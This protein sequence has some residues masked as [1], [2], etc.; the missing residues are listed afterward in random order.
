MPNLRIFIS[1][2]FDKDKDLKSNFVR[3]ARDYTPHRVEDCSLREA[4][5]DS[6]WKDKASKSIR[7]CDLVIVLVGQDTHNAP[8]VRTEI[9]I[10]RGL[11]K[12][13]FQVVPQGRPY[14]GLSDVEDRIRWKWKKVNRKIEHVWTRKRP[15]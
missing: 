1:F 9:D 3:Q 11:G 15:V 7:R 6:E 8:G 2:E 14:D 4:Y 13:V 10:A 5:P 12:P